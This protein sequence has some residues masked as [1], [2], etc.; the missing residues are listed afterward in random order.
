MMHIP[1]NKPLVIVTTSILIGVLSV[2]LAPATMASGNVAMQMGV[3]AARG[4]G[5]PAELFGTTGIFTTITNTLL[6]VIGALSVV[7]IIIGGLRYVISG[8]NATTVSAAKNTI[9]YAIIGLI[10]A[11]L[12]YAVVNFVLG[13]LTDGS[14]AG[15][16]I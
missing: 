12:A 10:V 7:M 6:F 15:T 16:D 2:V 5:Q 11:F 9:L 13:S 8:G 3:N 14:T 1:T 4:T